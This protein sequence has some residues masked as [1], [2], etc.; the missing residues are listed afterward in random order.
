TYEAGFSQWPPVGAVTRLHLGADG[1][2]SATAPA[3]T[4]T[5]SFRPNPAVRPADDLAGSANAWAAQPRYHWTEVPAA[6]GVAFQTPAFTTDTTIVGPAS[7][8]LML[9]STA[10]VTDLQVTVTEVQ[11]H[12]TCSSGAG[13]SST[14]PVEEYVTS[15]FLRSSNRT[16]TAASTALDPV[17]TYLAAD[18]KNLPAGRFTLVR[19][20][21]DPI[22]HT[23]RAGTSLRIVLSAPG[24]D[25]PSWTFLTPA[26]DNKVVDTLALGGA[27]G[28]SLVVNEVAGVVPTA[29]LPA[30]GSLRGEPCRA[31]AALG[32]Q[33]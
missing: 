5:A 19:I 31:D 30:C 12:G 1:A 27:D 28:S 10:K 6:N 16:L 20:P 7:L 32:N 15:G 18:R 14:G 26:T 21:V 24:G 13:C 23:F 11:P 29:A 3:R 17:P 8:D 25:R 33:S 2:L 9:K 4:T 22:A